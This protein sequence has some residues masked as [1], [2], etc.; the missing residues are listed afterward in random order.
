MFVNLISFNE[1]GFLILYLHKI[2]KQYII[3]LLSIHFLERQL[4]ANSET[5]SKQIKFKITKIK[6][7]L[8]LIL[9]IIG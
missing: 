5:K 8:I 2:I 6:N 1:F 4:H 3:L 7:Y 9:K